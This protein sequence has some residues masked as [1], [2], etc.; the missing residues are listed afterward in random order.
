M[1]INNELAYAIID[2]VIPFSTIAQYA[3]VNLPN[4]EGSCF[5]PFHPNEDT[6]AAKLFKDPDGDRI[7]CFAEQR[8]YHPS[9]IIKRGLLKRDPI[10]IASR[11]W[12][13][14]PDTMK[15]SILIRLRNPPDMKPENWAEIEPQ[16][17]QFREGEITYQE[18]LQLILQLRPRRRDG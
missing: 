3:G 6:P 8:M 2:S 7:Y 16:L 1:E 4:R 9:D 14:I 18:A 11:V 5:C 15:D 13:K 17:R 12:V 10:T